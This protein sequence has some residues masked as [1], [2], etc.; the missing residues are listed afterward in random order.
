MGEPD[1]P[2]SVCDAAELHSPRPSPE[3]EYLPGSS[4]FG[5]FA[6]LA[7]L[8]RLLKSA[9]DDHLVKAALFVLFQNYI[10]GGWKTQGYRLCFWW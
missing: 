6:S 9:V 1:G 8:G 7:A 4:F 5:V 10:V 3:A 2:G